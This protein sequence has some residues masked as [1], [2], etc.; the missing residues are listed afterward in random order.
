MTRLI[1]RW[2]GLTDRISTWAVRFAGFLILLAALLVGY[3]VVVRKVFGITIGGADELSG[4]A[5]AIGTTWALSFTLLRRANVRVDALYARLPARVTAALDVLA[6]FAMLLFISLLVWR[7]WYVLVDTLNFETRAPTPL[8]TPLWM[9]QTLWLFGYALFLFTIVP[10]ILRASAALIEGDL[11][12]VRALAGARTL[13]EDA[14]LEVEQAHSL[15]K[16]SQ[17]ATATER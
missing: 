2:I 1:D 8:A 11:P 9:P 14:G 12:K 10:L 16:S 6:L 15:V 5:F 13:E 7:G 3:E 4:Y 17:P